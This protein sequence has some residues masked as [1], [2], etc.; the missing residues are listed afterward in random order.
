M[1]TEKEILC[2]TSSETQKLSTNCTEEFTDTVIA[3]SERYQE[4]GWNFFTV[5]TNPTHSA[6]LQAFAAG[7]LEGYQYSD[8]INYH[9]TNIK[10]TLYN[11]KI[12]PS[13]KARDFIDQQRKYIDELRHKSSNDT[14]EIVS[15]LMEQYDGLYQGYL[16]GYNEKGNKSFPLINENDFWFITFLGD[17]YD[18]NK[19]YP[20]TEE[21]HKNK[22]SYAKE[23]TGYVKYFPEKNDIFV[24]H[25]TH[26]IYSMM[27]RIVKY[28]DMNIVLSSK[29]KINKM[30]FTSRPGDLNSKDDF[31]ILSNK[32]VVIETSLEVTSQSK[33]SSLSPRTLPKWI[34]ARIANSVANGAEDW[35]ETFLAENSGTHNDQ[36][37]IVDYK[38]IPKKEKIIYMVEQTPNISKKYYIDFTKTLLKQGYVGSY[39]SPYLE[40]VKEDL[41]TDDENDYFHAYRFYVIRAL[42][43]TVKG[44]ENVKFL[45]DYHDSVNLCNQIGSRCDI[46]TDNPFGAIDSKIVNSETLEEMKFYLRYGP[47]YMRGVSLPFEFGEKYKNFSHYGIPEKFEYKWITG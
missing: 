35:A 8:L 20:L 28:Y 15:F 36:W 27:N 7:Y 3:Y 18:I 30:K 32:M 2:Y 21:E 31:Y 37:L 22:F 26:N 38:Q 16:D 40:E 5:K 12:Q 44:I 19:A 41:G 39:N 33:Y 46:G 47:P 43:R 1:K 14:E 17:Y 34:R 13:E 23:C 9:F 45:I 25:N 42:D 11:G 4:E 6:L 29:K 24:A 10:N